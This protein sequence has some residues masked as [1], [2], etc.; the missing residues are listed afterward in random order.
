MKLMSKFVLVKNGKGTHF[1]VNSVTNGP[2]IGWEFEYVVNGTYRKGY[3]T[4]T[5]WQRRVRVF[6][7]TDGRT[8]YV[9][10]DASARQ[11]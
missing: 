10:S 5:A 4:D 2:R 11:V 6:D 3:I 1:V 8:F 7:T 9:Y